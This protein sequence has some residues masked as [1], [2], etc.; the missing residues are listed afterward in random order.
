[1]C[2]SVFD[3]KMF[4]ILIDYICRL[5]FRKALPS[6]KSSCAPISLPFIFHSHTFCSNLQKAIKFILYEVCKFLTVLL[7]YMFQGV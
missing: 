6:D 1:M 2:V 5:S 4:E 7:C 3:L